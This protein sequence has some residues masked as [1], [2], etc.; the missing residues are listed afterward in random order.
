MVD[1]R[2]ILVDFIRESYKVGKSR[3]EIKEVLLK[4][5]WNE[6]VIDNI[7]DNAYDHINFCCKRSGYKSK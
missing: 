4:S 7:V 3:S 2:N 1:E 5:D 6:K